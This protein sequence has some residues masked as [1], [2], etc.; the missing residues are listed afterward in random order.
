MKRTALQYFVCP[1]CHGDLVVR[2]SDGDEVVE[3]ALGCG[4]CGRSYPVRGGIPRFAGGDEQYTDTFGRQ[5]TRWR[6]TQHD[7]LN[8]T[9]I[10]AE[11]MERY[12]GWTPDSFAGKVVVDAGCGPG[13]YLDIS[14]RHAEVVIGFDL[15]AAIES[16]YELHG[17]RPNVHL[18]QADIFHPPVRPAIADRLY[19]F[20]VVQHTPDPEGAFR[21]LLPLVKEGGEAAV[22]VYRR[23]PVPPPTYWVRPFTRGMPEPRATEF[24]EWYVP[25][26]LAV[27]GVLG[28]VPVVGKTLRKLVPVADYRDR[29]TL[30]DEQVLEWAKMD[31]HDGLVTRY[32]YPQR[33]SDLRRWMRGMVDVR[34]PHPREM[35]A[36]GRRPD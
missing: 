19:T 8:G 18:A 34:K 27:S 35:S 16:A 3:G 9:T 14:E 23:W 30:T 33:W 11:R 7:S 24:I 6:S 26:A 20:G 2:E 15:S 12:T 10:Y 36:V 32:T 17:T 28:R 4:R 31:T 21:S 22:W 29:L 13:A 1:R 5:W 25:R